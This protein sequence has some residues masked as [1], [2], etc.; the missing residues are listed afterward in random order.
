MPCHCWINNVAAAAAAALRMMF[1]L[2]I[3]PGLCFCIYAVPFCSSPGTYLIKL[4]RTVTTPPAKR[5]MPRQMNSAI[6]D[7]EMGGLS[8]EIGSMGLVGLAISA[9]FAPIWVVESTAMD[10][11]LASAIFLRL[12]FGCKQRARL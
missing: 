8:V 3:H 6:V 9:I 4:V 5:P 12:V 7:A 11:S 10:Q 2:P 1:D